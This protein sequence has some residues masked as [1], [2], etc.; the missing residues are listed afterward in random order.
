MTPKQLAGWLRM[1]WVH[2]DNDGFARGLD[3]LER[4]STHPDVRVYPTMTREQLQERRGEVLAELGALNDALA[5]AQKI[6]A[7]VHA[8]AAPPTSP[9]LESS[10]DG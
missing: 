3:L 1:C 9:S 2:R 8:P 7:G 6:R 10:G 5:R 4:A